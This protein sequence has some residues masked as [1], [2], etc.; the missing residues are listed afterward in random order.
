MNLY[1][2]CH[3]N[4]IMYVDENGNMP[5]WAKVL[6][7][8]LVI[9]G[10][11]AAAVLTG[12]LAATIAGSALTGAIVNGTLGVASGITLD[13]NGW[14]FDGEK[15]A[16]GF[17]LGTITGAISGAVSGGLSKGFT[18]AGHF[19]KKGSYII[20]GIKAG[21]D[22]L[23]AMGSY[24][25]QCAMSGSKISVVGSFISLGTGL[26][27]FVDPMGKIDSVLIPTIG[28]ELAWGYDMISNAI[29][30]RN[31]KFSVVY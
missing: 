4:P 15:A 20:R 22:G 1:A 7:D 30:K 5:I 26:L 31:Q 2:Y 13:E 29:K 17:M 10:A 9:V 8:S 3:N 25:T 11:V 16:N 6:V 21:V 27:N 24:M 28:A 18:F 19:V 14:S 12:E 23:L